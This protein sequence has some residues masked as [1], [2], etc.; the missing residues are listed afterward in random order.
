MKKRNVILVIAGLFIFFALFP[1][2]HSIFTGT[3]PSI[4][5]VTSPSMKP[6]INVGDLVFASKADPSEIVASKE[7]GD[8][9]VI[10]GP[11]YFLAR[12]YPKEF[13]NLP[14]NT[15]I[16]HRAI[17]KYFDPGSNQWFFI[18]KGDANQ[19]IDGGWNF[20][21]KSVN[22]SYYL[23]EYNESHLITIPESEIIGKIYFTIPVIGYCAIFSLP[24]F[25]IL[26]ALCAV[27]C[28][29]ELR[30]LELSIKLKKKGEIR[31][32]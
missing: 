12:G 11:Q 6:T 5:V 3:N 29:L 15:P 26:I 22:G 18:T 8:I 14:N 10:R 19:F 30:G 13:L 2:I 28:I 17:E 32:I 23:L 27:F 7:K 9:L 25:C 16:I 20:L 21:N 4:F 24:I 31:E 1:S